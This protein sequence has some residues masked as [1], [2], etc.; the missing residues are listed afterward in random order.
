MTYPAVVWFLQL[1]LRLLSHFKG[2]IENF[3]HEF[4]CQLIYYRRWNSKLGS[5]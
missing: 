2:F 3:Y 5:G 1:S 4:Y